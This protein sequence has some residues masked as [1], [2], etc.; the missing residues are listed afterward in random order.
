MPR[1]K[2]MTKGPLILNEILKDK[3]VKLEVGGVLE[4]SGE[5]MLNPE[6]QRLV[7]AG[8]LKTTASTVEA[9]P[10]KAKKITKE[11][12]DTV[13][14]VSSTKKTQKSTTEKSSSPKKTSKKAK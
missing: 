12:E 4:V 3:P 14:T 5:V 13:V 2:N 6:I 11:P 7:A 9:V 10:V 1:I 8:I